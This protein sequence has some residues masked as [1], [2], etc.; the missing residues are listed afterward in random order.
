MSH[1]G[2]VDIK[3]ND[4]ALSEVDARAL[5]DMLDSCERHDHVAPL[6]EAYLRFISDGGVATA[7][8]ARP[9]LYLARVGDTI[10]GVC[11]V[12]G[13]GNAE[14]AVAP[15]HRRQGIATALMEAADAHAAE[16]VRGAWAHGNLPAAR[17]TANAWNFTLSRELYVMAIDRATALRGIT[18][19]ADSAHPGLER[20]TF[21]QAVQRWDERSVKEA[22]LEANNDAF[23]WHPE[24]GGWDMARLNMAIDTDWF[25]ADGLVFYIDSS[26]PAPRVAG[27]HFTQQHGQQPAL[28]AGA[29]GELERGEVYVVG[30]HSDYQGRGLGTPI[31]A[32]GVW[33][34]LDGGAGEIIL[35][36]ESDNDA[37]V[38]T[39]RKMGFSVVESHALYSR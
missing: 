25:D 14:I 21:R 34:L 9:A 28:V 7:T 19:P 33:H 30:L 4:T 37:A 26:A 10:V 8:A 17:A 24:Q 6:S 27:F 2:T 31:V 18:R 35:Y 36:V 3:F 39:Y 20:M 23:S 32:E 38:A 15:G 11:A 5:M 22:W 29:P 16:R 1:A 13:D 12:L